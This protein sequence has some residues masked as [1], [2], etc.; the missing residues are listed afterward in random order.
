[1]TTA[2]NETP[3]R[4]RAMPSWLLGQLSVHAHRMLSEGLAA[5]GARGHHYRLLAALEEFGPASQAAL[6][7]RTGIDRSDVVAALNDLAGQGF[8]E[9]S[10]DPEDRRRNVITITPAGL[11]AFGRLDE[12]LAGV[13]E[14][15]LAPL[16]AADRDQLT[17]LLGRLLEHHSGR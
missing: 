7:R 14:E 5:A 1:M 12:V 17:R 10:P 13:Q 6:G 4:L 16:P 3:A 8:V 9:R 2:E 15:L 11:E